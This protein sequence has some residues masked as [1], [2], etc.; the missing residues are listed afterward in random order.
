MVLLKGLPTQYPFPQQRHSPP[1][2]M[3]HFLCFLPEGVEELSQ[4]A[5]TSIPASVQ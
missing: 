3:N 1:D 2:A 5:G 4:A